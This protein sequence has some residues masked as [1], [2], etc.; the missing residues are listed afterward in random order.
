MKFEKFAQKLQELEQE[1]SRTAMTKI[2]A[3]IFQDASAAE[4]EII[5]YFSLG[6]LFPPY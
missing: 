4:A 5:A 3:E 6:S 1:P 2:L